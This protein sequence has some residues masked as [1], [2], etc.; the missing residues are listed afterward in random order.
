MNVFVNH[1]CL[2]TNVILNQKVWMIDRI[3]WMQKNEL[4]P[5]HAYRSANRN[6]RNTVEL[7]I[8]NSCAG[9]IWDGSV[10]CATGM[11][12]ERE[13]Q[14]CHLNS[15]R[16]HRLSTIQHNMRSMSKK[17]SLH[18]DMKENSPNSSSLMT[19][20]TVS[21]NVRKKNHIKPCIGFQKHFETNKQNEIDWNEKF[22]WW[23]L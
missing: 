22:A 7:S 11:W 5:N 23:K 21:E 15:V 8:W 1:F 13:M 6:K 4:N 14:F 19:R 20:T 10:P 3:K 17:E 16:C 18:F 9:P 2:E 12:F